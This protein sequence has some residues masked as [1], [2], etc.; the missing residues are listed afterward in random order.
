M[1]MEPQVEGFRNMQ[2]A[3]GRSRGYGYGAPGRRV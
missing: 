2:L 3:G 1:A